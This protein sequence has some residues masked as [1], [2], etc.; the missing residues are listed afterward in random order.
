MNKCLYKR[1]D[2]K[3]PHL[4]VEFKSECG[5]RYTRTCGKNNKPTENDECMFCKKPI[6]LIQN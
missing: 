2:K 6:T 3:L 5:M 1:T 4:R